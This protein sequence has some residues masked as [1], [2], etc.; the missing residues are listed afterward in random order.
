MALD[1][2]IP[3]PVLIS[4][5]HD[6][7]GSLVSFA[8][9]DNADLVSFA[10]RDIVREVYRNDLGDVPAELI[11]LGSRGILAVTAIWWDET[12]WTNLLHRYRAAASGT[13]EGAYTPG[14]AIGA[15]MITSGTTNRRTFGLKFTTSQSGQKSYEFPRCYFTDEGHRQF[16]IGAREKRLAFACHVIPDENGLFYTPTTNA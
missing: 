8:R 6:P 12:I 14:T 3:G 4:A 5:R 15:R 13:T 9:T 2:H 11:F 10:V 7:A 1:F 16:E